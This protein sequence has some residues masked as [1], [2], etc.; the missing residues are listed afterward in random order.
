MRERSTDSDSEFE[1][2]A[3]QTRNVPNRVR[4][5]EAAAAADP[6]NAHDRPAAPQH[7][8]VAHLTPHR[9]VAEMPKELAVL[10]P[11]PNAAFKAPAAP[12][13]AVVA[14]AKATSDAA[15]APA[16]GAVTRRV[17]ACTN[18]R[19]APRRYSPSSSSNVTITTVLL[20]LLFILL[21]V[22]AA[23]SQDVIVL[24][25]LG[26]V[27]EKIGV[28]VD[29]GSTQFPMVLRL[30]IHDTVHNNGHSC[31]TSN[32]A[33]HSFEKES[34]HLVPTWIEATSPAKSTAPSRREKRSPILAAVGIAVE[35]SALFNLFSGAMTSKEI[36]DIK[37]KQAAI[38][39]HMQTL[40]DEVSNNHNDIVKI[41][42]SV[43]SLY[44][45]THQS[46]RNLSEKLKK[47]ECQMEADRLE[48]TY[49]MQRDR[50]MNKLY[51]DLVNSIVSIFNN[52]LTFLLLPTRIIKELIKQNKEFF[53]NTIY[54]EHEY[55][56]YYYGFIFPVANAF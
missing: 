11:V 9:V 12:D 40:D 54:I 50:I 35:V 16:N 30:V 37:S 8:A 55:L 31:L 34:N 41:A 51:V 49:G 32:I 5:V 47:F 26:A 21:L 39:N 46:F 13:L 1:R 27:A 25:K 22:A 38:F 2:V 4:A 56:V 6:A 48:I 7:Q 42:T 28:D 52:H 43:G 45:Y 44:E 18:K 33:R 23:G 19:H 24:P 29:L 3:P 14:D 15:A 20:S 53:D 10:A 36:A 17:S